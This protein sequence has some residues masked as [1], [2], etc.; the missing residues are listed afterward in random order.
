MYNEHE[1]YDTFGSMLLLG[2]QFSSIWYIDKVTHKFIIKMF[3]EVQAFY[4]L[5]C[6]LLQ[7]G[8]F[9]LMRYR[10]ITCQCTPQSFFA[11][12]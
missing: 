11:S 3:N 6:R 8:N 7:N 9:S 4:T 1:L 5:F 12:L 2:Y 10:N